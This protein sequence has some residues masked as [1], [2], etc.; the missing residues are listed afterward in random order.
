MHSQAARLESRCCAA[1]ERGVLDQDL[2]LSPEQPRRQ[3]D[4]RS[5]IFQLAAV[6]F[7]MLSGERCSA[8]IL[9]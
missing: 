2:A 6:I 4:A 5:D 7:E 8:V 9:I 3:S 1:R